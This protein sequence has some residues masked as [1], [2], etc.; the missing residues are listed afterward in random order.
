MAVKGSAEV[1]AFLVAIVQA[2]AS[3]LLDD[4]KI[5]LKDLPKFFRPLQL[6]GPAIKDVGL[7][8]DELKNLSDADK[9]ALIQVIASE[10]S[11]SDKELQDNI[12]ACLEA[13]IGLL[14]LI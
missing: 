13:A 3:S 11:L 5:T 14:D 6:L 8:K 10:L 7:V 12:E 1:L 9:Q 4:G 2:V